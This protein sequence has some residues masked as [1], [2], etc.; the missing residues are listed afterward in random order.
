M[1]VAVSEMSEEFDK[2]NEKESEKE[3]R[4]K[5]LDFEEQQGARKR[6]CDKLEEN[7]KEIIKEK[8]QQREG[9]AGKDTKCGDCKKEV[10]EK[11][12][13]LQCDWCRVWF[14]AH[15]RCGGP[16]IEKIYEVFMNIEDDGLK[17][18]C[19]KCEKQ[20]EMILQ[21]GMKWKNEREY[22][23]RKQEDICLVESTENLPNSAYT[24][25]VVV[26]DLTPKAYL[27]ADR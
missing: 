18:F 26:V 27:Q 10:G 20:A 1:A 12:K 13:A 8:Y 4:P 25:S 6:V 3:N 22:L 24:A 17:W 16:K 19:K 5:Q 9:D 7:T 21:T 14:H 23:L 2:K 11:A 15:K